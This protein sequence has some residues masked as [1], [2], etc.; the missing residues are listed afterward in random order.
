MLQVLEV[1]PPSPPKLYDMVVQALSYADLP[2]I[3][4]E[5]KAID[6]REL[7]NSVDPECYLLPCRSGGMD[8]LQKPVYFL[9]ER[10]KQRKNWVLIGCERRS[11]NFIDTIM[12]MSHPKLRCVHASF[13]KN[14]KCLHY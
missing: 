7:C 9:D 11:S 5:L 3:L 2:P 10:P 13:D 6:V 4:V 8:Q 1:E 14:L 12:E